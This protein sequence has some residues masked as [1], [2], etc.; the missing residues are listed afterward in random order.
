M[1]DQR[2][3]ADPQDPLDLQDPPET[4]V[5]SMPLSSL[6]SLAIRTRDPARLMTRAERCKETRSRLHL[7]TKC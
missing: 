2:V 7:V 4:L 1:K 3:T 6:K 5:D